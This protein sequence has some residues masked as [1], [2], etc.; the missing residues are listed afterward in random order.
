MN[1]IKI[2]RRC[3]VFSGGITSCL[4]RGLRTFPKETNDQRLASCK[5]LENVMGWD[6]ETVAVLAG[7]MSG[8]HGPG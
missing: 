2:G 3:V 6:A 8:G 5:G 4:G 1:D 7:K